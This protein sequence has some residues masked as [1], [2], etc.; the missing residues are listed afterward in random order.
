MHKLFDSWKY[1]VRNILFILPFSIVPAVFL[2]LA[3]DYSEIGKLMHG[4]FSGNPRL[5]FVGYFRTLSFIRIDS[6]LGGIF[7]AL[8]FV[9][10]V[11]FGALMISFV[12]KHMRIG[13]RTFSGVYR[14]FV[15]VLFSVFVVVLVYVILYELWALL[16]SAFL[17]LLANIQ[18]NVLFYFLFIV[19][20]LLFTYALL[21]LVTVFY[22]WLPCRQVTG[23]GFYDAF[24]YSYRLMVGIRWE[25]I[26][27]YLASFVASLLI[28]G[29]ASLLPEAAFRLIGVLIFVLLFLSFCVR[30]ET[31]YFEADKLD[32]E[33][34][35]HSYKEY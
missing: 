6:A 22:L 29:L 31:A 26:M 25:L 8:A 4:F 11:I 21:F 14:G 32:R 35:L 9:C 28:L 13:K 10:V 27:S 16:F 15:N 20:F 2:A 7:S 30:M 19:A 12:E 17:F 5:D 1:I 18:Q 33:D 34:L 23:F 24:L 3:L